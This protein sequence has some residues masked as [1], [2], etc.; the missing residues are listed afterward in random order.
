MT[1]STPGP[2]GTLRRFEILGETRR[3]F[4]GELREATL[5]HMR[6]AGT[7]SETVRVTM[8]MEG[9]LETMGEETGRGTNQNLFSSSRSCLLASRL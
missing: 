6:S 9:M 3:H 2:R 8:T 7:K 1:T 4:L 5:H